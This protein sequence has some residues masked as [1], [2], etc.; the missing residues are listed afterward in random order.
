MSSKSYASECSLRSMT[1]RKFVS[2]DCS[3]KFSHWFFTAAILA[4]TNPILALVSS[5]SAA[6]QSTWAWTLSRLSFLSA[7][8]WVNS[9]MLSLQ[10]SLSSASLSLAAAKSAVDWFLRASM[11]SSTFSKAPLAPP[12]LFS[13]LF[14]IGCYSRSEVTASNRFVFLACEVARRVTRT[15]SKITFI[16]IIRIISEIN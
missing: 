7:T 4:W 6:S 8:I 9:K 2:Q 14:L 11:Y 16:Y 10:I 1:K 13:S 5:N 3:L 12:L 15:T